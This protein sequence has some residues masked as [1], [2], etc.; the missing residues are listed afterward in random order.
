MDI[1][2]KYQPLWERIQQ[3][4]MDD[5]D[6]DFSFTDRLARENDWTLEYAIRTVYEYKKFIMLILISGHPMTPSDQ[7]DQVWH[8]HLLYTQSYWNDWCK[9]TLKFNIHHGPTKGGQTEKDK[10]KD[11]YAHT[12]KV[13]EQV[14]QT[15]PP[16][17]IWPI[18]EIRFGQ[19]NFTRVNRHKNWIIP[20]LK[21]GQFVWKFFQR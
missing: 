10:Y 20:K 8:L 21:V 12:K 1:A 3:F 11:L 19:I 2:N 4:E 16:E 18:H 5:V 17:E 14:F 15:R 7:I 6:S 13:Y 9:D